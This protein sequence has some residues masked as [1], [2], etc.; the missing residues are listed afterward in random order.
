MAIIRSREIPRIFRFIKERREVFDEFLRTLKRKRGEGARLANELGLTSTQLSRIFSLERSYSDSDALTILAFYGKEP[1][2]LEGIFLDEHEPAVEDDFGAQAPSSTMTEIS[3]I[4]PI[5]FGHHIPILGY[6]EAG[7]F[8]EMTESFDEETIERIAFVPKKPFAHLRHFAHIVR[9]D[10]MNAAK[11]PLPPG[12][13]VISVDWASTGLEL[14]DGM[15][16]IVQRLK[17]GGLMREITVKQVEVVRGGWKLKPMST[18]P[19]HKPLFIPKGN[20]D[21]GVEVSVIGKVVTVQ[22]DTP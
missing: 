18:N 4:G 3:Q 9:G 21:D 12:A 7:M 19:R 16:V 6:V 14:Q 17:D 11:P 10:S 15:L 1:L 13:I 8:Q 20:F 2:G 5:P 22:Q